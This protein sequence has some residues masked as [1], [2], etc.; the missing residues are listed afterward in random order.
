MAIC[1]FI[2]H[3]DPTESRSYER[4]FPSSSRCSIVHLGPYA[5]AASSSFEIIQ[6]FLLLFQDAHSTELPQKQ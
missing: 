5:S 2:N 4:G 1:L 6:G 3:D